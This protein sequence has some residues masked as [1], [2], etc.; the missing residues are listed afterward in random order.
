MTD[1]K[2]YDSHI[3]GTPQ[4][5]PNPKV[6]V[7]FITYNHA[8]YI[9]IA[10]DSI[11]A[12]KTNFD[13]ELVI[14]D[15][16]STD[17]TTEIV[18]EYADKYPQLVRAYIHPVNLTNFGLPGKLNFVHGFSVCKGQY[19]VH[20]EGDDYFIDENKLQ[21]Q[22]DFLDTHPE[23]SACFHNALMKFEDNSGREDYPI[24]GPDQKREIRPMDLLHER[25]V[26]FMATAAV[27]FRKQIIGDTFPEW[28]LKTKS[29]DIP[30]YVMLSDVAP[31]AYLDE[32]M[33]VYRRHTAG[34]S[35]T[36]S[37]FDLNF[38]ENRI[39]MYQNIDRH[40]QRHYHKAIQN[41]IGDYYYMCLT[42]RQLEHSQKQKL[43]YFQKALSHK[44]PKLRE[45][46]NLIINKLLTPYNVERLCRIKKNVGF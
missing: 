37:N 17:G 24:N 45:F 36:D 18:K 31:I 7:C 43:K 39:L 44:L 20:I 33:S 15:D 35:Y 6:S 3:Y 46:K 12:Q 34:L 9:R 19:V 2:Q 23:Y 22:A 32:V 8:A 26:W 25:E 4:T 5:S 40:T 28:F 30:L 1:L 10:L 13:F 11:I 38:L 29:G 41:I 21:K 16:C 14:G 27:M 42:T